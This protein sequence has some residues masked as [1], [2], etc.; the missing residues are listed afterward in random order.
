MIEEFKPTHKIIAQEKG[1][2]VFPVGC[3]VQHIGGGY[4][5]HECGNIKHIDT[6]LVQELEVK[7]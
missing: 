6:E 2:F 5:K 7:E 3:L 1:M 4:Y